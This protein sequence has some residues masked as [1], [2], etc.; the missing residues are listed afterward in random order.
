MN[1]GSWLLAP[2]SWLLILLA[3]CPAPTPSALTIPGGLDLAALPVETQKL[4]RATVE[5][6]DGALLETDV[7]LDVTA[8][9]VAGDLALQNITAAGARTLT[10][11]VY[12]RHAEE[13]EEALLGQA[14]TEIQVA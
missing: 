10:L 5:V 11:R 13:R 4:L 12:G 7:I 2:G 3:A 8:N 9:T 6:S 14:S 1:K